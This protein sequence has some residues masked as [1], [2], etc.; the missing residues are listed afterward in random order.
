M[1]DILQHL[2]DWL[3]RQTHIRTS[4]PDGFELVCNGVL[5]LAH[6][7]CGEE[8]WQVLALQVQE[9]ALQELI[10]ALQSVIRHNLQSQYSLILINDH[11]IFS[12]L[13][14]KFTW[15]MTTG[16]HCDCYKWLLKWWAQLSGESWENIGT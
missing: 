6:I 2:S 15:V 8:L 16:D 13:H 10:H 3:A 1:P 14:S 7:V 4:G 11:T 5:V 9:D 12:T